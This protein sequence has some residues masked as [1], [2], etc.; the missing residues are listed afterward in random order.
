V[1]PSTFFIMPSQMMKRTNKPI[2]YLFV[3][4]PILVGGGLGSVIVSIKAFSRFRNIEISAIPP[5]N[6]LL[7]CLPAFFL[8]IPAS[9]LI[10]N[11]VAYFVPILRRI[12]ENYAVRSN[13]PGFK[14]SQKMLLKLFWAFSML[15][16]P[17]ILLGFLL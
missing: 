8:W 6:G 4:L 9:L 17:L 12:A 1:K 3:I 2:I 7:I 13:H 16:I 5:I 10:S 11:L 14:E 15:C